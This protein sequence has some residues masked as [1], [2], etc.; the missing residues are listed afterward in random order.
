MI[1]AGEKRSTFRIYDE[2]DLQTGDEVVFIN[3][4]T[5]EQFG[6]ATLSEVREKT[7]GTLSD[8]DW[9]GHERFASEDEMYATYRRYY[10]DTVGPDTTVKIISFNFKN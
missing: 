10:G 2:K 3:K 6:T 8:V 4:D 7:L 1:Q 5:G 9:E